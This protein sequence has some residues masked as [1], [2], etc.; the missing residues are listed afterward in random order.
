MQ[1][2]DQ[3]STASFTTVWRDVFNALFHFLDVYIAYLLS[4]LCKRSD[5]TRMTV[6]IALLMILLMMAFYTSLLHP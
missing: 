4:V 1:E 3:F 6:F 5:F 2:E